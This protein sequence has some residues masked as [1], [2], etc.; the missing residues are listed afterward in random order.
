[1]NGIKLDMEGWIDEGWC[2][3]EGELLILL[4]KRMDGRLLLGKVLRVLHD[5]E[6]VSEKV[7]PGYT[8]ERGRDIY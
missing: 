7:D 5:Q 1:M 2:L 6:S 8:R 4:R 3:Y